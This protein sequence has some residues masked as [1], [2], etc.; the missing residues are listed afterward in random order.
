M[1]FISDGSCQTMGRFYM[2]VCLSNE[3]FTLSHEFGVQIIDFQYFHSVSH[4]A[5]FYKDWKKSH[6]F[7]SSVFR[8]KRKLVRLIRKL[9]LQ[10]RTV[11]QSYHLNQKPY[12]WIRF[13]WFIEQNYPIHEVFWKMNWW[14]DL[15][16]VIFF[17][18]YWDCLINFKLCLSF[19][20]IKPSYVVA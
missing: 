13:Y 4:L 12:K 19:G 5:Y 2:D 15:M 18:I 7:I 11:G 9:D 1:A 6:S 8:G 20:A 14:N 16:K 17:I 3:T 10:V